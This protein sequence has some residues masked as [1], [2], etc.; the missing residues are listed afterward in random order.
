M[1]SRPHGI[2]G[3][4]YASQEYAPAP[5]LMTHIPSSALVVT[6]HP[7]DAEGGCGAAMARWIAEAGTRVVVLMST[8]G[9]KGT[10]DKSFTPESL[11]ATREIEQQNASRLLGVDEVVFLRYG[12]GELE[13]TLKYRGEVVREIRRH[14]P[15]VIFCIDPYRVTSHTHRDHRRSGQVALDAAFSYAWSRLDFPEQIT[16]EGLET[17][18]VKE[19]LLWGSERPDTFIEINEEYIRMKA[20]SLSAHVSQMG[21]RTPAERL[22]RMTEGCRMQGERCGTPFAE[23]FRRIEFNLGTDEWWL[24]NR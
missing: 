23:G 21:T 24:L 20:E 8:N 11:A 3:W 16:D 7:D 9:N 2:D 15:E 12:D 1:T 10:G 6:P 4:G 17:H 13:D 22:E 14:K 19:A 18:Q 5:R